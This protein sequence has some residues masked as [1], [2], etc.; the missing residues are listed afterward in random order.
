[1]TVLLAAGASKVATNSDGQTAADRARASSAAEIVAML[2]AG[3]GRRS[4]RL[5]ASPART[6]KVKA[7]L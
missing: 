7:S 5:A 6:R 4:G 1:M 2:E 3:T